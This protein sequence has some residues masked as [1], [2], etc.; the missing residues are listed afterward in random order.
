D[1]GPAGRIPNTSRRTLSWVGRLREYAVEGAKQNE[2]LAETA[3]ESLDHAAEDIGS[4]VLRY[5]E[6]GRGVVQK[7]LVEIDARITAADERDRRRI[8]MLERPKISKYVSFPFETTVQ[9]VLVNIDD[10]KPRQ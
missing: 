8:R 4:A 6:H 10:N 9:Q 5:Y 3:I 1:L 7:R 2:R